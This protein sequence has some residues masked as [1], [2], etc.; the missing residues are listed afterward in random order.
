MNETLGKQ[1][2]DV[3]SGTKKYINKRGKAKD[4]AGMRLIIVSLG[5]VIAGIQ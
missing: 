5:Q 2:T 3:M 4:G 1:I